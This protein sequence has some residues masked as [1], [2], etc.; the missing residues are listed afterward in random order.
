MLNKVPF[1]VLS[2]L[3]LRCPLSGENPAVSWLKSAVQDTVHYFCGSDK[4][5]GVRL[6]P[7]CRAGCGL[8]NLLFLLPVFSKWLTFL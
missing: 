4:Q 3:K 5:P 6:C 7:C 1:K 8:V 2:L